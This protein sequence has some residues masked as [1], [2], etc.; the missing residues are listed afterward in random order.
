[1]ST[2]I[3]VPLEWAGSDLQAEVPMDLFLTP[4][5]TEDHKAVLMQVKLEK[6]AKPAKKTG[7][8]QRALKD[9]AVAGQLEAKW[10]EVPPFPLG[11]SPEKAQEQAMKLMRIYVHEVCETA[12]PAPR[13]DWI[14]QE[15]LGYIRWHG[16]VRKQYFQGKRELDRQTFRA[17]FY[18]WVKLAGVPWLERRAKRHE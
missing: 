14:T 17:V 16:K 12:L 18:T 9:E 3:C 8:D 10:A 1:M 6:G 4:G 7:C 15:S 11:W 5:P 2:Y 13:K